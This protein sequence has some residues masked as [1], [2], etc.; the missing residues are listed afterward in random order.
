MGCGASTPA[1]P[2]KSEGADTKPAKS[3]DAAVP[4]AAAATPPALPT[5]STSSVLTQGKPTVIKPAGPIVFV[6]GG[7][8]AGKGT[9]C[10]KLAEKYGCTV[11]STGELLKDSVKSGSEQ[12]TM[13]A[14]MIKQGQ[15]V[16]SQISLDLLKAAMGASAGPYV[17]DGFPRSQDNLE[18][19]EAQCGACATAVYLSAPDST[20]AE[21][22]TAR[23]QT[24]GRSDDNPDT[25]A[26]RI[27][28]FAEQSLPVVRRL[29]ERGLVSEV[30]ASG[31][32][33]ATF[34]AVCAAYEKAT[35]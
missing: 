13:I 35:A 33:D 8:G 4:T 21:R 3:V 28:T 7:P 19:F 29:T 9:V 27:R 12:G 32:L 17:I 23:G 10:A 34:S 31:D 16:P 25:I 14:N 22:C 6:V 5:S 2:A 30:D 1:A 15:I 24:T 18:A 11:L 20:L 26:R